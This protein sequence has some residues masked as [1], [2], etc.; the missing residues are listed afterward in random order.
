MPFVLTLE[1]LEE[2]LYTLETSC[3]M[4]LDGGDLEEATDQHYKCC[5]FT[6]LWLI[7]IQQLAKSGIPAFGFQPLCGTRDSHS[8]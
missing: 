8:G 4:G 7:E 3:R 5:I 2:D 1:F 6:M